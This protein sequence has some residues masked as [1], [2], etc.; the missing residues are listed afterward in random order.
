MKH[1][2]T[3]VRAHPAI[4]AAADAWRRYLSA[5]DRF[6]LNPVAREKASAAPKPSPRESKLERYLSRLP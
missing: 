1:G 5:L 2:G 6:G 4:A 3:I